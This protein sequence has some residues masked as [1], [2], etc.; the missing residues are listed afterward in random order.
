M[1]ERVKLE[2]ERDN[3]KNA[4]LII[5]HFKVFFPTHPLLVDIIEM[6][7]N[8]FASATKTKLCLYADLFPK[9]YADLPTPALRDKF[10][11]VI[12]SL[13]EKIIEDDPTKINFNTCPWCKT[14][15]VCADD[16]MRTKICENCVVKFNELCPYCGKTSMGWNPERGEFGC[17]GCMHVATQK[18][19]EK[20][21]NKPP[22]VY[23]LK[24]EEESNSET[25][26]KDNNKR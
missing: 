25:L 20:E 23:I 10:T 14:Y 2:L 6:F 24:E 12:E 21:K 7:V 19:L 22:Q 18:E 13:A 4:I 26:K 9:L 15:I 5:E 16:E 8:N 3:Y 1:F 17:C 11:A